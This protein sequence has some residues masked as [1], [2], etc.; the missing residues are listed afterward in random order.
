MASRTSRRIHWIL[1]LGLTVYTA[2][3]LE[4]LKSVSIMPGLQDIWLK[5]KSSK[6]V[7]KKSVF[8]RNSSRN[9]LLGTL[10][11]GATGLGF[12]GSSKLKHVT[13]SAV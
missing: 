4:A 10:S 11:T 5:V 8:T 3:K 2:H 1:L 12:F 9:S 7:S 13:C 6:K